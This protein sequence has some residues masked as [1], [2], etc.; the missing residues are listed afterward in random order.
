[1]HIAAWLLDNNDISKLQWDHYFWQGLPI[2]VRCVI[3]R[4]FEVK[5]T[6]YNRKTAQDFTKV[7][8]AG[9]FVF[10]EEMF[11]NDVMGSLSS[12]GKTRRKPAL[13]DSDSDSDE[14]SDSDDGH[15]NA[16]REVQARKVWI[17]APP[18]KYIIDEVEELSR[19]CP[20]S[21]SGTSPIQDTTPVLHISP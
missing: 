12:P 6:D 21:T 1:M 7:L 14:N 3:D 17:Y 19:K 13:S 9:R 5:I 4:R 2:P 20:P 10:S 15:K 8:Q 18:S 16:P 11:D